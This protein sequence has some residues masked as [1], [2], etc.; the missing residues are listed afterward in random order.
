MVFKIIEELRY[1]ADRP[2][3]R[4]RV[5]EDKGSEVG[6]FRFELENVGGRPTSLEPL[7]AVSYWIPRQGRLRRK[8]ATYAV[9]EVDRKL[10][11]Y[12]ARIFSASGSGFDPSYGFAWFRTFTIRTTTGH[13]SWIH[14]RH[15]LLDPLSA[16]RY[17]WELGNYL[18][19]GRLHDSGPMNLDRFEDDRRMRG[20][21]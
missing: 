5:L 3:L 11:P 6:G 1:L 7:I 14:V 8:T 21:H 16:S 9:R 19:R 18:L 4:A 13:W 15:A 10:A 17:W 12:E 20:P 2:S